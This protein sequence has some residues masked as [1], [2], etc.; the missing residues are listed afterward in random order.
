MGWQRGAVAV[1]A[2]AETPSPVSALTI[3]SPLNATVR[4][5]A[6][7]VASSQF[8]L[9]ILVLLLTHATALCCTLRPRGLARW[10]RRRR[11]RRG[12]EAPR[13]LEATTVAAALGREGQRLAACRRP[14]SRAR[15]R[16]APCGGGSDHFPW[17]R[18]GHGGCGGGERRRRQEAGVVQFVCP[19]R[20]LARGKMLLSIP[21]RR[22][23]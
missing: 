20:R 1:A 8:S 17:G 9:F 21:R 3:P 11:R 4:H 5:S 22:V 12:R 13:A 19:R 7:A 15:E 23:L 6:T 10:R 16:W 18:G 2:A 14:R